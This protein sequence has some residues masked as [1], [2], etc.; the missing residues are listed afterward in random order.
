M[1]KETVYTD[2]AATLYH[3]DFLDAAGSIQDNS[4]ENREYIFAPE[5][6]PGNGISSI[7]S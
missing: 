4:I 7:L 3:A 5:I 2:G 6:C 1:K